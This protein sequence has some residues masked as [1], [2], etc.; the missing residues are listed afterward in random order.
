[1]PYAEEFRKKHNCK[2]VLSTFW[3]NLF[4][5]E[6]P[7]IE[8]IGRGEVVHNINGQ[9]NIGWYQPWTPKLNPNDFRTIPLQ[10]TATDILGLDYKEIRPKISIPDKPRAIEGKYVCIGMHSTAQAKYWNHPDGWQKITDYLNEKG[11]KVVHISK[12]QGEYMGN[13]PPANI[14]DKTGD[15]SIEDRL[16][17]LKYADM[18][19]GIG[20]G[21]SWLSW[22]VGTPTVLISGFSAP[23]CEPTEGIERIH[24]PNVCNSCFNDP[25]ITFDPGDWN[26]CPRG[27]DFECSKSIT[28]EDV[29]QSINKIL[30]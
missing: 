7:E 2:V 26:W 18:Y 23:F 3:N 6:Y 16:V 5:K 28:P 24:N 10:Q 13:S 27:K 15:F 14:I 12:E 11:Y 8:F 17:D 1:M 22:A 25:N 30:S 4:E 9:H 19:I 20:S 29:I 21:L